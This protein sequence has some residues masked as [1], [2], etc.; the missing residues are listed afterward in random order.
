MWKAISPKKCDEVIN[1]N[2]EI[3]WI[4][5]YKP[6][7]FDFFFVPTMILC[8]I[9]QNTCDVVYLIFILFVQAQLLYYG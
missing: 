6:F 2:H 5:E 3:L 7:K 1:M 8:D 9:K 4:I